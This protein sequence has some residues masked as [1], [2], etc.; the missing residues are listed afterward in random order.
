MMHLVRRESVGL[1][2]ILDLV[3]LLF[4]VV[5]FLKNSNYSTR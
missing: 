3:F 2:V 1:L 4:L 5:A